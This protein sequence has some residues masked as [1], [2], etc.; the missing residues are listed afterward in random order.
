[1]VKFKVY[2]KATHTDQ[3]LHFNSHHPLH[4]NLGIVR[5]LMDRSENIVTTEEF[6]DKKE[7]IEH[8]EKALGACGY[9]R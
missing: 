6:E 1:M 7:E 9:P 3:Y 2:R 8:V 4:Q 5:T